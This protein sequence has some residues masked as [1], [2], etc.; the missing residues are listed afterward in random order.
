M[1]RAALLIC[2]CACSRAAPPAENQGV[3]ELHE[4][5]LSFEVSGRVKER[6][7]RRG[8]R[9]EAGQTLALLDDSLERPQREARA[10]EARAADAQLDLLKAGTRAEDLR[11]AEAQLRGA[12]A[13][14][15]TLRDSLERTKKLRAEGTVPPSQLDEIQGQHDRARAERQAAEERLAALR[16]GA[17]S[18][19]V[20]AALARSSQAH[21]QL[22]AEDARLSRFVLRSEIPGVV[23]DTHVEP[24]EVVQPG[25]PVVTVGETRRPYLDVFVPQGEL[26]E[27]A[28]G[29]PAQ[30]RIDALG[31]EWFQGTVEMIGRSLEFTPRYLFSEKERPNLVVRVRI[32]LQDPGE[33]LHAGVPAFARISTRHLEAHK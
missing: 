15:D 19:E 30:V 14:E 24:G 21:A 5:V 17:R 3:I 23:L 13:A 1:K 31:G 10:A 28:V 18:Q 27:M 22:D 2:A 9:V 8:E 6:R 7:V 20:R 4:R 29:S 33:R 16:A 32:D 11:A 26:G 12:R 25:T